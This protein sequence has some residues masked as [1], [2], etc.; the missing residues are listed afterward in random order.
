[1]ENETY[2]ELQEKIDSIEAELS[3]AKLELESSKKDDLKEEI[4]SLI[5]RIQ[6]CYPELKFLTKSIEQLDNVRN[7][8][9]RLLDNDGANDYS[10]VKSFFSKLK[11]EVATIEVKFS[12][13][14]QRINSFDMTIKVILNENEISGRHIQKTEENNIN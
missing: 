6:S 11:E 9:I 13:L 3:K 12:E 4:N 1:M 7:I 14:R 8:L 2:K 5:D 10:L